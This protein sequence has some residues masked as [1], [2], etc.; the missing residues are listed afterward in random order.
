MSKA[1]TMPTGSSSRATRRTGLYWSSRTTLAV[2]MLFAL[3]ASACSSAAPPPATPPAA[4]PTSAPTQVAAPKPAA[5]PSAAAA[6]PS[7]AAS[8]ASVASPVA[9]A[10]P[11]APAPA[12][13]GTASGRVVFWV[14]GADPFVKAHQQIIKGFQ[15][16]NPN[17]T[18]D[19]QS[20]PFADFNTKVVSSLPSGAG[21]DVLEAYSP[22]MVGYIRTGLI[23]SVPS[24]LGSPDQIAN[25]YYTS[26]L[27]L[28]KYKDQYF[29]VPS[30]VAAGSTRVLLVNDAVVQAAGANIK[31]IRTFDDWI[32]TWKALTKT[33][34]SGRITTE[35]LGQSC[36]QPA[37]QFVSYLMEYGGSLMD[38]TGHTAALNSDAGKS[39]L[40]LLGD[41][42]STHK[43][44]SPQITDFNCIPQ[45]SA[46]TGYRGSWVIPEYKK[47]FPNFQWHYELMP[48]PTGATKDVWQGGS[49]WATY[50]PTAAKNKDAAWKFVTYLESHRNTWIDN[51][52]E[53]P[54]DKALAAQ[55]AKDKPDLYGVY[56]PILDQSVHGYPYG[57]YFVIYQTLSDMVTSVTLGQASVDS[58]LATAN[59]AINSHLDQWWSQYPAS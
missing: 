53:I 38:P 15:A 26:T 16:E 19:L 40:K 55:E 35:G 43:V 2:T 46:A 25:R 42:V 37:D 27:S 7:A 6:S 44:D 14:H 30:N 59:A 4:Q 52:S 50:V 13:G 33:D 39:A 45:G 49:G 28:L 3:L 47:D 54:A 41:L 58:A 24:S 57:D 18:V 22:W 51:T 8:P 32:T 5:S 21:P 11:A 10:N 23:D 56:Y 31:N 12:A 29:G 1:S 17:V 48:L 9:A 34:A 36:G 20:F